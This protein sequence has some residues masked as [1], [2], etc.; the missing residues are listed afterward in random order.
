MIIISMKNEEGSVAVLGI[1]IVSISVI[2]AAALW[3]MGA[4]ESRLVD[5]R[6]QEERLLNAAEWGAWKEYE[7]FQN[8]DLNNNPIIGGESFSLTDS[9]GEYDGIEY[10]VYI[11]RTNGQAVIWSVAETDKYKAQMGYIVSYDANTGKCSLK[12][13]FR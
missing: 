11:K 3:A 9:S 13:M 4:N 10:E 12:G 6:I 2:M 7:K 1:F 8:N 5:K